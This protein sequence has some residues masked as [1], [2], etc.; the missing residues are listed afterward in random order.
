MGWLRDRWLDS[1]Y[2]S[3]EKLAAYMLLPRQWP[4]GV[5]RIGARSLG[6]NLRALDKAQRR[7]WW[8]R[9][10][11]LL[12]LLAAATFSDPE[13]IER[14]LFSKKSRTIDGDELAVQRAELA[15]LGLLRPLILG[16]EE[17]PPG[18]PKSVLRPGRWRRSW[19]CTSDRGI[20]ALI[21]KWMG[22]RDI[23]SYIAGRTWDDV[24]ARL[25]SG[26]R[27][28]VTL[29]TASDEIAALAT[30]PEL[31][32]LQICVAAPFPWDHA[33]LRVTPGRFSWSPGAAS[34]DEPTPWT[35]VSCKPS[36]R[37]RSELVEWALARIPKKRRPTSRDVLGL[38]QTTD[39]PEFLAGPG[40]LL[41][42]I[43][44]VTATNKSERPGAS[45]DGWARLRVN[46]E[47][48]R[49]ARDGSTTAALLVD[50]ADRIV[51][52]LLEM[53]LVESPEVWTRGWTRAKWT[54][55]LPRDVVPEV[56]ATTA[57][58]LIA[59]SDMVI[60]QELE[61]LQ[62]ALHPRPREVIDALRDAGLLEPC[63]DP[64]RLRPRRCWW[65]QVLHA[66][67]FERVL[68]RGDVRSIGQLALHPHLADSVIA[69]LLKRV[70][71]VPY[72][73]RL[74][75]HE[76]NDFND[77]AVLAAC[78]VSAIAI[79]LA[80]LR[81]HV[82]VAQELVDAA[83][84]LRAHIVVTRGEVFPI[85]PLQQEEHNGLSN[86]ST[87]A[88]ALL[89]LCE[90]AAPAG[91]AHEAVTALAHAAG[92]ASCDLEATPVAE[93]FTRGVF[94][95]A[96][97]VVIVNQELIRQDEIEDLL[98]PAYLFELASRWRQ[99][100]ASCAADTERATLE[101]FDLS[102][103]MLMTGLDAVGQELARET[104]EVLACLWE[105]WR[106]HA[107][108]R[109]KLPPLAWRAAPA[110]MERLWR[111]GSIASKLPFL[112][113]LVACCDYPEAV[114]RALDEITW[115]AWCA[116]A[117][118]VVCD[119]GSAEEHEKFWEAMPARALQTFLATCVLEHDLLSTPIEIGWRTFPETMIAWV[120]EQPI[121]RAVELL[122]YQTREHTDRLLPIVAGRSA[123]LPPGD[124]AG[125][126]LLKWIQV[127]MVCRDTPLRDLLTLQRVLV[128]QGLP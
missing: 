118:E 116:S 46:A 15:E 105:M 77:P 109:E 4:V 52:G 65:I 58:A 48:A 8:R 68:D 19:W 69:A 122:P 94:R 72:M 59:H 127:V 10:P 110:S 96:Q 71:N 47:I 26:G 5:D 54:A 35:D 12:D 82:T 99:D 117:F 34:E 101:D 97:R 114:M 31:D 113:K 92:D 111:A 29:E 24:R 51:S 43:G 104:D 93:T 57:R 103:S 89:S 124:P 73:T 90:G 107:H 20:T 56:D 41:D 2:R 81:D 120:R 50:H 14:E 22:A 30:A 64:K 3:A 70:E 95:L 49:Q 21:G 79:G 63:R 23:A 60:D 13:T 108:A 128:N 53:L 11:G 27:V 125:V 28:F 45:R 98:L 74:I 87:F 6:N 80:R 123:E 16:R 61:R 18:I 25:P 85:I 67:A 119:L 78:E 40:E 33:E 91:L 112:N 1:G 9:H 44:L 66:S 102:P 76:A 32:E 37:E 36:E 100:P 62:R 126:V 7:G 55:K 42:F 88:L 83:W 17:L 75:R 86:S 39:L 106:E 38:L 84:E 121:R 115:L